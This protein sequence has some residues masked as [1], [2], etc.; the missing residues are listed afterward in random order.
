MSSEIQRRSSVLATFEADAPVESMAQ[1][2]IRSGFFKDA[3]DV[4]QAIVKIH[5]GRELGFPPVASMTGIHIVEGKI[6]LSAQMIGAC[7]IKHG[8]RYRTIEHTNE[9]CEVEIAKSGEVLGSA[10]Y[11]F[12]EAK[13]A[14]LTNKT[15]WR[16]YPR[17][18]LLWRALAHAVRSFAPDALGGMPVYDLDEVEPL[19]PRKPDAVEVPGTPEA[20]DEQPEPAFDEDAFTAWF[21]G[22]EEAARAAGFQPDEF[23]WCMAR[24]MEHYGVTDA[25]KLNDVQRQKMTEAMAKDGWAKTRGRW[26]KPT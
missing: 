9:A 24:V 15:N 19:P 1:H 4:S 21:K 8:Y 7:A 13:A 16:N 5:A 20:A 3:R 2:M 25:R 22:L 10:R 11:T 14:G 6:T 23:D 12:A 18:M 26:K 17:Q